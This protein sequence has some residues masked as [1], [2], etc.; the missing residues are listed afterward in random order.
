MWQRNALLDI[1][2]RSGLWSVKFS[3]KAP[4]KGGVGGGGGGRVLGKGA[5]TWRQGVV[6][7]VGNLGEGFWEGEIGKGF[8]I[9]NVNEE[10]TQ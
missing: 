9:G 2:G 10:D 6:G 8:T 1:S 5:Y 7:G 4:T 3:V